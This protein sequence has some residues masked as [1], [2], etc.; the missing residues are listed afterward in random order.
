MTVKQ[1]TMRIDGDHAQVIGPDGAALYSSTDATSAAYFMVD[2]ECKARAEAPASK[3]YLVGMTTG[4]DKISGMLAN[5][6]GDASEVK[7]AVAQTA[8][9]AIASNIIVEEVSPP[10]SGATMFWTLVRGE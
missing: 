1:Y 3:W 5:S 10:P 4:R 8:A 9:G 7:V 2:Q 6:W